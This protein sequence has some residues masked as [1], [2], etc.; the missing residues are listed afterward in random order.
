[1]SNYTGAFGYPN[2][3]ATSPLTSLASYA[4]TVTGDVFWYAMMILLFGVSFMSLRSK[5]SSNKALLTSLWIVTFTSSLLSMIGLM[6]PDYVVFFWII[7][8]LFSILVYWEE[9]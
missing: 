3:S 6:S 8:G 2:L 1:M 5:T 9:R 4:N 7:T